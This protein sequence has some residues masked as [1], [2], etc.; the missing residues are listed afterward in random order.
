MSLISDLDYIC[1]N[2]EKTP[3]GSSVRGLVN[4]AQ[5]PSKIWTWE[6]AAECDYMFVPRRDR[7]QV[8]RLFAK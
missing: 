2:V 7:D 3:D 4:M 8:L 1:L 6:N 5:F